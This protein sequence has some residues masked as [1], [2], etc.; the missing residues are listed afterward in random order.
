MAFLFLD[1]QVRCG[2]D[3]SRRGLQVQINSV[4]KIWK[5]IYNECGFNGVD[6]KTPVC[7]MESSTCWNRL[8]VGNVCRLETSTN[9]ILPYPVL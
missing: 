6:N 2:K 3:N 1:E 5:S 8:H 4:R 7:W 9:I